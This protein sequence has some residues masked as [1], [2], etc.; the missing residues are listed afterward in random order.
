MNSWSKNLNA[1]LEKTKMRNEMFCFSDPNDFEVK[2]TIPTLEK[3]ARTEIARF[4]LLKIPSP[5][6]CSGKGL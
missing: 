1:R 3:I 6:D 2:Q 4:I 5:F